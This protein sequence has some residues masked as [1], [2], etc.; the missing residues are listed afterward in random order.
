MLLF[1]NCPF[2]YVSE[3][4]DLSCHQ[5]R[6]LYMIWLYLVRLNNYF[7]DFKTCRFIFFSL[8]TPVPYCILHVSFSYLTPALFLSNVHF[9]EFHTPGSAIF[10]LFFSFLFSVSIA[11]VIFILIFQS[12]FFFV[13]LLWSLLFYI[14]TWLTILFFRFRLHMP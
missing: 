1:W 13:L 12:T 8:I 11:E 2:K 14:L 3:L 6:N 4:S 5:S 7:L 10:P 9:L